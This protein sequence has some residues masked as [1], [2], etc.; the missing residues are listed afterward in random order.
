MINGEK[1]PMMKKQLEKLNDSKLIVIQT[2]QYKDPTTL[3]V[4]SLFFG[5]L[6]IDRIMLGETSLGVAKLLTC[7]GLLVW[8]IVDWFS[9]MDRTR[10]LNY[11]KFTQ[12]AF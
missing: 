3:L 6:G 12:V 9:I 11:E 2:V 10:E 4:V 5:V 8:A 1:L 7:G